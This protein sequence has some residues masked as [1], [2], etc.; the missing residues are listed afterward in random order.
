MEAWQTILAL[1]GE[2]TKSGAIPSSIKNKEQ[3]AVILLAG[4]E[5]GIGAVESLGAFYICNGKVTMYGA[6][7][8]AQL[9]RA[10]YKIKWGKCDAKEVSLTLTAPDGD[11]HT[12]FY[13]WEQALKTGQTTKEPWVKYPV[14]M[15]RF[16]CLGNATRFFA[17]ET[18][19]GHYI[20]EEMDGADVPDDVKAIEAEITEPTEG[21]TEA[22]NKE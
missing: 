17:P 6:S 5:A 7:V 14:N 18:T 10:G 8:L 9:R 12:E 3:L 16:K 19:Y 2:F 15:L 13:T 22:E 4:K 20:R 21:I 1:G 11:Q